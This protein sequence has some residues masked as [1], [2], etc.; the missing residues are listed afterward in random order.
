M[1]HALPTTTPRKRGRPRKALADLKPQ[2]KRQRRYRDPNKRVAVV[3]TSEALVAAATLRTLGRPRLP[4]HKLS[5]EGRKKRAYRAARKVAGPQQLLPLLQAA[6]ALDCEA[7]AR[8]D[9]ERAAAQAAAE[10]QRRLIALEKQ[11]GVRN[12]AANGSRSLTELHAATRVDGG[13]GQFQCSIG[14]LCDA[15]DTSGASDPRPMR[16]CG[17][18]V[19]ARCLRH[20]LQ[21]HGEQWGLGYGDRASGTRGREVLSDPMD[22]HRCPMCREECLSVIRGLG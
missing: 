2:S 9:A 19:C 11:L 14:A 4:Y 20:H 16:C 17:Q 7:A 1:S 12:P 13:D 5:K 18:P 3:A 22:A 15:S 10:K 8:K 21:R 6:A